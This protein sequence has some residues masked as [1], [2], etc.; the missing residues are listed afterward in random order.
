MQSDRGFQTS[1]RSAPL[2]KKIV[3]RVIQ[4]KIEFLFNTPDNW[5]FLNDTILP[6][7]FDFMDP[8]Q[9]IVVNGVPDE[10]SQRL[11]VRSFSPL[12][13]VCP[14]DVDGA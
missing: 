10:N 8:P 14:A 6:P 7:T 4:Q 13:L 1:M 3:A 5:A 9:T 12:C 11:H 2:A